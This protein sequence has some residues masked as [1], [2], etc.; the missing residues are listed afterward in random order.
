MEVA[1]RGLEMQAAAKEIGCSRVSLYQV[2][3]GVVMAP[4]KRKIERWLARS[5]RK[6]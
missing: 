1:R 5:R 2:L 6:A 3:G 4:T